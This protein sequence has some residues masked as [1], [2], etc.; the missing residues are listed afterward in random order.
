MRT[1]GFSVQLV[2]PG[3]ETVLFVEDD[4]VLRRAG[5]RALQKF[6]YAVR[7]ARDGKEALDAF[8]GHGGEIDLVVTDVVMPPE[9]H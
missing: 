5:Q 4:D 8:G 1:T 7:T 6:G 3:T 2:R 9:R